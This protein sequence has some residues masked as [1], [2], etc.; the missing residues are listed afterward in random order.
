LSWRVERQAAESQLLEESAKGRVE[1]FE[2][3]Q[4]RD[5]GGDLP[6]LALFGR[7]AQKRSP[8]GRTRPAAIGFGWRD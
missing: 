8:G 2:P 6:C 5:G 4:G 1:G 3:L 7:Q